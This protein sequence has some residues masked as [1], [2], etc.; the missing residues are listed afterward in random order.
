LKPS[1]FVCGAAL[2]LAFALL[3]VSLFSVVSGCGKKNLGGLPYVDSQGETRLLATDRDGQTLPAEPGSFVEL[4][5]RPGGYAAYAD[6]K[7]VTKVSAYPGYFLHARAGQPDL[8]ETS[9]FSLS[10]PKSWT[11]DTTLSTLKIYYKKDNSHFIEWI[12]TGK[13]LAEA[14]AEL[15]KQMTEYFGAANDGAGLSQ[16]EISLSFLGETLSGYHY[17][18]PAGPES[19][20]EYY[21]DVFLL[22]SSASSGGAALRVTYAAPSDQYDASFLPSVLSGFAWK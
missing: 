7:Q 18:F 11:P 6:G 1:R 22:S 5:T 13:P 12:N 15:D 19:S 8:L 20:G 21:L 16:T 10:R 9:L 17:V 14:Q 3:L 4:E 2:P